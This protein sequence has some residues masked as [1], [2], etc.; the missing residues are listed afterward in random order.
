MKRKNFI[1][2]LTAVGLLL[3]L[4]AVMVLTACGESTGSSGADTGVNNSDD[5]QAAETETTSEEL[6]PDLPDTTYDDYEFKVLVM[7]ESYNHY[8]SREIGA[9]NETGEIINDSVYRRNMY[10]ENRLGV[11]IKAIPSNGVMGEAKTAVLAGDNSYDVVMPIVEDAVKALQG[12]LFYDLN[13]IP[14]LD[15]SKPW[16]DPRM[17]ESLTINDKCYFATGDISILDN[18]CTMVIFFNKQIITDHN[19]D[20]PYELVRTG[21]WTLDTQFTMSKDITQDVDGDG[22]FSVG[23]DMFGMQISSNTPHSMF[24]GAGERIVD[25]NS[26]GEFEFTIYNNRAVD[27][28]EK[29]F[30]ICTDPNALT[31][32]TKGGNDY[33]VYIPNFGQ[34][35]ILF[36]HL[37]LTD[38]SFFRNDD[39][40]FGILP[41]AKYN[42]QQE[43]YNSFISTILVPVVAIPANCDN[44]ERTG[45]VIEAMA[46][47]AVGTLTYAYYDQTLNTR[48]IRDTESSDM[49]DIIF[50][51]RV[52][53]M[54]FMFNWGGMGTMIQD[55]YASRN[56]DFTSS[57]EK[58][59]EKAQ[60]AMD[61]SI[62]V[63]EE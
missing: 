16:W 3:C 51:T 28:I 35:K 53:D 15:L 54:G 2:K 4:T 45:A 56:A 32:Q 5:T 62:A 49:L 17:T 11:R 23:E 55:M 47:E 21:K 44:T 10:V 39:V 42:E 27:V 22:I 26:S 8:Q 6:K 19:L 52:Y 14:Y 31:P 58:L 18:E 36:S 57:Y 37:A 63:F 48:L 60:T 43:E 13:Q 59:I 9:E 34:G 61:T 38:I 1:Y 7:G 12:G 25:K 40:D 24:F 20:D 46:Y 41:Y 33:T 50:N 29:I 30:E